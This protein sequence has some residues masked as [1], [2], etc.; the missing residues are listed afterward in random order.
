MFINFKKIVIHNFMSY[1]HSEYDLRNKN[2]CRIVGINN[3]KEDNAASNG[4]GKS[5]LFTAICWALTGKTSQ[6]ISRKL[7]NI[8]IEEN[9]C[10][11]TLEF[12]VDKDS[13]VITRYIEPKSNL[14]IIVN[15]KDESGKGISESEKIL[16]RYLPDLNS[17]LI[18]SMIILGQ[19][20]PNK[21][22]SNTPSGRKEVLEK[23]SK[24]D[25]MIEDL[26]VRINKR[27]SELAADLRTI[28]DAILSSKSKKS[29]NEDMKTTL[30]EKFNS[31]NNHLDFDTEIAK[32][33]DSLKTVQEQ[34]LSLQIKVKELSDK[35]D[36]LNKKLQESINNK[37]DELSI[38]N[39]DFNDYYKEYLNRKSEFTSSIKTLTNKINS[40]KN[41]KDICPTCGQKI[42]NVIK[43]STEAEELELKTLNENLNS[44]DTNFK[45]ASSDHTLQINNIND[46]YKSIIDKLTLEA[47]KVKTDLDISNSSIT[48]CDND[49]LKLNNDLSKIKADKLNHDKNL[50]DITDQ[51]TS[52]ESTIK[53]LDEEL[54]YNNEEKQKISE[55][56]SVVNQLNT[57]IKR[58]FR[59]FLLSNIISFIN[60]KAK[61]YCEEIF[62]TT[63]IEFVLNGNDIDISYCGKP[64]DNLS[65][66]ERQ[67]VDL[68]IQFSI[69]DMMC[70]Y[71]NFNCNIIVLDE[72]LDNLDVVGS[73]EIINFISKKL[74]DV[75][76]IFIISHNISELEIP[77]DS[78]L[79][80]IK[81]VN[82]ISYIK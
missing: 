36:E 31:L 22:T 7:K 46:K 71:L 6:G 2:F 42:P 44:L 61:E 5:T 18:S 74:I 57:L 79:I 34:K 32:I 43:P 59:G 8:N 66:G 49:L 80:V 76:S 30:T 25:F 14:T 39:N 70:Q 26:K 64:I 73:N 78:E 13:Y 37:N 41:I 29:V 40:L 65:G 54:L 53:K 69:R 55:R 24:S 4:S 12:D 48:S 77:C 45:K 82:G 67:K 72:I 38:D 10:Y 19:G 1:G 3:C 75:E 56:I 20:L 60:G 52:C 17:N 81:D 50:K 63:D 58:D 33:E 51:L 28:E 35:Y 11:V 27:A 21:F 68:I 16:N 15:G 47:K 62:K 9:S 23:L